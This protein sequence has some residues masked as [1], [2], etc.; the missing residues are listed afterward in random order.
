MTRPG[1]MLRARIWPLLVLALV[2][3]ACRSIAGVDESACVG[4]LDTPWCRMTDAEL[5]AAV[6]SAGGRVFVGFKDANEAAGVDNRG[7]VLASDTAV[8]AGKLFLRSMRIDIT[9]EFIDMPSVVARMAGAQVSKVRA[10]PY[11]EYIEPIFPGTLF[12][13][14]GAP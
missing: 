1:T 7:R 3:V 6:D 9:F 11:V 14:A 4:R 2:A 10:N 12:S 5:A 13:R 8:A